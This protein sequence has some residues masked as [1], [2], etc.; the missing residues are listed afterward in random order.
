M[1]TH[2]PTLPAIHASASASV[3][4][5]RRPRLRNHVGCQTDHSELVELRALQT[6]LNEVREELDSVS[7]ELG[8]AE[9]RMR[10]E[11]RDEVESRLRVQEER[12]NERVQFMRKY[13]DRHI[14]QVRAASRISLDTARTAHRRA[15]EQEKL[16]VAAEKARADAKVENAANKAQKEQGLV[17][18]LLQENHALR[19]Q[20]EELKR[21]T[22]TPAL[23]DRVP[24]ERAAASSAQGLQVVKLEATLLSRDKTIAV[25]RQ[26]LAS[27]AKQQRRPPSSHASDV[28]EPLASPDELSPEISSTLQGSPHAIPAP[29]LHSVVPQS[30]EP[31]HVEIRRNAGVE[32]EE[33]VE[34]R[35][36]ET[37]TNRAHG[38]RRSQAAT[39]TCNLT[40]APLA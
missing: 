26:Q 6:K 1:N 37:S 17:Q 30:V 25:L 36:S 3:L 12:C 35:Q 8:F 38:W 31:I 9:Q 16:S 33:A 11:V 4:P 14:S 29:T 5:P 28:D 21:K 18:V 27:L 23:L 24:S 19:V 2:S 20:I 7:R 39:S 10:H 32:T 13:T 40:V 15:I 22:A 34:N